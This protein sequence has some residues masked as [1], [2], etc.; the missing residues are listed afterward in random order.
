MVSTDD[1]EAGKRSV[2]F[3]S[4]IGEELQL[5]YLRAWEGELQKAVGLCVCQCHVFSGSQFK[6][7]SKDKEGQGGELVHWREGA[8]RS[9][10]LTQVD[11]VLFGGFKDEK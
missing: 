2:L 3:C 5:C 1:Q 4:I 11:I 9:T 7:N 8:G 6:A 10:E